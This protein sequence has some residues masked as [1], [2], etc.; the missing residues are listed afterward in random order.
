METDG[1]HNRAGFA[2]PDALRAAFARFWPVN[3]GE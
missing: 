2:D 1:G 3:H